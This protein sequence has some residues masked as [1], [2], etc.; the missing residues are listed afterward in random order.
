MHVIEMFKWLF[1]QKITKL[2]QSLV[3]QIG[4]ILA[5]RVQALFRK[6][7]LTPCKELAVLLLPEN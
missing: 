3:R 2:A 5:W 7:L 6:I 1:F 4:Q